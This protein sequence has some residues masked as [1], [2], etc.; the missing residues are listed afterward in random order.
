MLDPGCSYIHYRPW[1]G[2][3]LTCGVMSTEN[4]SMDTY[5]NPLSERYASREMLA[6]FSPGHRYRTWRR[7]WIA[8]A[9]SQAELGL[10][11]QPAQIEEMRRHV[12]ELDLERVAVIERELRHDVMAHITA[13][14]ELCPSAKPI[15]HLGATSCFV[16][17][18]ADLL[19]MKQGL[20]IVREKLLVLLG[21]LRDFALEH[22]DLPALAYTHFQPAQLTTVGKRAALW[23]QDFLLDLDEA[24]TCLEKLRFRGA[25]GATGTQASFLQLFGGDSAKVEEL[26]RRVAEK[27]GFSRTYRV[28]GQ[29]YSRKVDDFVCRVLGGVAQSA[30]KTT[31]DARLLQGVGEMSEPFGSKQVG[32]SAMPYKR[33]PMRLERASSLA[34]FVLV[35]AQNPGWIH[36][37]QW[38]ERTLDDSANRRISVPECFLGTDAILLLLVG[39]VR[40]FEVHPGIIRK[41]IDEELPFIASESLLM[42]AVQS[43]GDRQELHECI[44]QHAMVVV[45]GRRQRGAANDL[46]ERLAQDPLFAAVRSQVTDLKDPRRYVGR[47]PEQVESFFAEEVTPL[48]KRLADGVSATEWEVSV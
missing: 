18:N 31:T 25:K 7:L 2:P 20:E 4:A 27:M 30:H 26:D 5:Q 46:L 13:Y 33:N 11:I 34:K 45:E 17:D 24:V 15:I 28:T 19:L 37:T 41:R 21:A 22:K 10:D 12:D 23:A 47:A 8:L 6:I 35:N 40:G 16:T 42:L 36:A 39:V 9:E 32:S 48:L 44:R 3:G 43:G 1:T 29:T 14:G 38:M